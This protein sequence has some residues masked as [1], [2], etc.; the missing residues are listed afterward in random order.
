MVVCHCE[1][2]NDRTVRAAIEEGALDRESVTS[3]CGA[4]RDCGGCH[5]AIEDLLDQRVR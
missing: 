3:R 4:G 2:I 1:A 5:D